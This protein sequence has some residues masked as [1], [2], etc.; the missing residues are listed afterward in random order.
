MTTQQALTIALSSTGIPKLMNALVA[1]GGEFAATLNS[2]VP[3]NQSM[4]IGNVP[5]TNIADYLVLLDTGSISSATAT[6]SSVDQG[7]NNQFT[8]NYSVSM[9]VTYQSWIESG[10]RGERGFEIPFGPNN[11]GAFSFSTSGISLDATIEI[12]QSGS[13]WTITFVSASTNSS[14]ATVN[15]TFP[16]SSVLSQY[17]PGNC[18]NG[19]ILTTLEGVLNDINYNSAIQSAMTTILNQLAES[20]NLTPSIT[21]QWT[22]N[23][24]SFPNP[25]LQAGVTGLVEYN[26]TAFSSS[27]ITPP[28][29]ALPT[30]PPS[31]DLQLYAADYLFSSLYWAYYSAGSLSQTVTASMISNP[32]FLNTNG[33]CNLIPNFCSNYPPST[34]PNGA[35]M[36]VVISQP[37]APTVSF[38]Q[39]YVVPSPY[40]LTPASLA[41]IQ[42]QIP[43][44]DYTNL[45]PILNIGYTTL[46]SFQT[47]V[48]SALGGDYSS[49]G[50]I[51]ITAGTTQTATVL[52][53]LLSSS[54]YAD[55]LTIQNEV[56]TSQSEF[57]TELQGVLGSGPASQYQTQIEQ[58]AA[59]VVAQISHTPQMVFSVDAG[60]TWTNLWTIQI[61]GPTPT[62]GTAGPLVDTL[63][64]FALGTAGSA[65]T[66]QAQYFPTGS[67]NCS[68]TLISSSVTGV[69]AGD[70]PLLWDLQFAGVYAEAMQAVVSEGV[71]VPYIEGYTFQDATVALQPG[72]AD[73]TANISFS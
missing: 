60:G 25:G 16:S 39:V 49:Y 66:L 63:A 58:V 65:Q 5:D 72:Y 30:V 28:S 7:S 42:S 35:S 61:N 55:L 26:G 29:L 57:V 2:E 15:P 70:F 53:P 41:S 33:Y 69:N 13:S 9:T 31:N 27:S 11:C 67:A 64:N 59:V 52:E 56:Y 68:A 44:T 24:F 32:S 45:Q 6:L 3:A 14:G 20:G 4:N 46:A 38:V 47:A 40:I 17:P 8:L 36:Q 37:S 48:Q 1:S 54:L 22:P 23:T 71:A 50:S 10:K 12:A 34:Y 21:F 62:S 43:A 73:V 18:A 51:V 19:P